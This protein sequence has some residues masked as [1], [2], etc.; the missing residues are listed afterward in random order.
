VIEEFIASYRQEAV[1]VWF[2]GTASKS[3]HSEN[4]KNNVT[5]ITHTHAS[6]R[7][8]EHSWTLSNILARTKM[9]YRNEQDLRA[10]I[11]RF[12]ALF[13]WLQSYLLHA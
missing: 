11:A 3:R 6:V 8:L 1:I 4:T 13:F 9:L 7:S 5:K 12:K 10:I 2:F